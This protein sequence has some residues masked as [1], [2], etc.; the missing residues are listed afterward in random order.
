MDEFRRVV[1][2]FCVLSYAEKIYYFEHNKI[3]S[4]L[5]KAIRICGVDASS[6]CF[7]SDLLD[8]VCV[9]QRDGLGYSFT[10]RSFQEYFTALF[11][12]NNSNA[13]KYEVFD[14]IFFVNDRDSVLD[15]S[16]DINSDIVEQVWLMPRLRNYISEF[17]PALDAC[18]ERDDYIRL[19]GKMFKSITVMDRQDEARDGAKN[20]HSLAYTYYDVK[21]DHSHFF[22]AIYSI[23]RSDWLSF[24]EKHRNKEG[25]AKK[26]ENKLINLIL[27]ETD[28]E[29]IDL[30]FVDKI[31]DV[32]RNLIFDADCVQL[33]R[34]RIGF[35]K[36]LLEMLEGKYAEKEADISTMLLG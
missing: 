35:A 6:E 18:S 2:A 3:I 7:L 24:F 33:I 25:A 30:R 27:N 22:S 13:Q 1:S 10:H 15:M 32:T 17:L 12:V 8:S 11:L 16:Y 31:P 5:S 9:L 19:I 34:L 4:L 23:F 26:A 28:D 20:E 36:F 29:T 21:N 14:K